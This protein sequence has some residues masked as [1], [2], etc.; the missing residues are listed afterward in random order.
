M[1]KFETSKAERFTS[2]PTA[3]KRLLICTDGSSY[4]LECCRTG[5]WLAQQTGA[6]IDVLYVTD[7][8]QF[9]VPVVIDLSG[10]LGIQPFEGMVA[11]M[12]EVEA[13]KSKFVEEQS[14]AQF[15]ESLRSRVSFHHETGLLVDVIGDFSV[16]VDLV[17]LGKRGE[18]VNFATE[19]LGSML[20][21]VVRTA[22]KPCLV[23]SRQFCSFKRIALAYDGGASC[24]EALRFISQR[25]PF[26]RLEI[27]VVSVVEGHHED[28]AAARLDDA[29][30]ALRSAG[31]DPVCQVLGGEVETSIADYIETAGLDLLIAGAYGHSR[32]REFLIGSTTTELLRRCHVPVL[33]FR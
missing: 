32:I 12:Q 16:N 2:T 8:R 29:E 20:E 3:M 9:E 21:R 7:L 27:H 14:M 28:E 11:Q 1:Q 24:K 17:L 26:K 33:C 25:D 4:S 6:R 10:S 18:N 19:H 31:L 30:Q 13:I 5:A 22:R 23:T 15:D